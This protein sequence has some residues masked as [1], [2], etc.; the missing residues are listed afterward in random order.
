MYHDP[1]LEKIEDYINPDQRSICS[2]D[3][4]Y[5]VMEGVAGS[6]KTDT[7]VRLGLRRHLREN[8]HI[9]TLHRSVRLLMKSVPV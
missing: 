3:A 4:Q 7:M 9:L 5:I 1:L 6:R 8:K 2:S